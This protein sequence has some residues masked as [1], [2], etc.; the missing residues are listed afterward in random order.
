MKEVRA[1]TPYPKISSKIVS[2]HNVSMGFDKIIEESA[3]DIF[4]LSTHKRTWF[5][6]I[7]N[8]SLTSKDITSYL[9][10]TV[11]FSQSGR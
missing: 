8:P 4:A 5:E 3:I 6:K 2:D 7:Y 10:S 11:C 1:A 9:Y